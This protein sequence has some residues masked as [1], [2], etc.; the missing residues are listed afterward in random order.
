[1]QTVPD[2]LLIST[3]TQRSTCSFR[4]ICV[5]LIFLHLRQ[6]KVYLVTRKI[7]QLAF[8]LCIIC[9][10]FLYSL[11]LCNTSFITLSVQMILHLSLAP[12]STTF[13]V[14]LIYFP[15]YVRCIIIK[16]VFQMQFFSNLFFIFT[17]NLLVKEVFFSKAVFHGNQGFNVMYASRIILSKNTIN[18]EQLKHCLYTFKTRGVRIYLI[19]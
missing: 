1:M 19:V 7:I 14:I 4:D 3:L 6:R 15:K 16:Y 18:R 12:Y 5:P 17:S 10:I 2:L 13:K 11:P 9:R 8:F